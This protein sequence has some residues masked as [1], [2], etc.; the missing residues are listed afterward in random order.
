MRADAEA[1]AERATGAARAESYAKG[2]LALGVESFTAMQ[3]ATVLSVN[4]MKLV[5]D[6]ALAG[7]GSLADVVMAKM[8]GATTQRQSLSPVPTAVRNGHG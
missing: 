1:G 5:P 2:V 8:I 3:V 7:G 6:I 4:H